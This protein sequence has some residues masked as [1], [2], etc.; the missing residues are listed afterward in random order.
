[1]TWRVAEAI[2]GA[3]AVILPGLRHMGL[4]ED[5]ARFN[6]PLVEFLNR[7]LRPD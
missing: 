6:V 4:A 3:Q 7:A 1:M 2:A 5:P